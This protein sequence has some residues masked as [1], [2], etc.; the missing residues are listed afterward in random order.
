MPTLHPPFESSPKQHR[1]L[2][3]R[4]QVVSAVSLGWTLA[5]SVLALA[6]GLAA[7]SL[8]LI[9]FAL[10]GAF[11]AVGSAAL[12]VHFG[13]ARRL[14]SVSE[15]LERTVLGLVAFGMWGVAAST[16]AQSIIRLTSDDTADSSAAGT[17]L[18][19]V[20]TG[21]LVVLARR[22]ASIGRSVPSAAL[23]A[24]SHLTKFGAVLAL[25][26]LLG[27][28]GTQ[29]LGWRWLDPGAALV[30]SGVLLVVGATVVRDVARVPAS[31]V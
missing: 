24:D 26:T 12:V 29:A 5:T 10:T 7:N 25:I 13:R 3:A 2:L 20:A 27:T 6:L 14:G 22:K 11:D 23:I 17:V 8:V 15:R 31:E 9:A 16:G 18:A 19:A 21:S 28:A 1:A 4:A 30:A